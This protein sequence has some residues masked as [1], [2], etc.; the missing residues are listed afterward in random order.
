MLYFVDVLYL[1]IYL[2][3]Y[4]FIWTSEAPYNGTNDNKHNIS[5]RMMVNKVGY[6]FANTTK[7]FLTNILWIH[8]IEW[9]TRVSFLQC[10]Y[11]TWL[12]N[13][14]TLI[15]GSRLAHIYCLHFRSVGQFLGNRYG[16][17]TGQ[18][19]LDNLACTGSETHLFNCSHNG[20][21]RHNCGHMEDVSIRCYGSVYGNVQNYV[22]YAHSVW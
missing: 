14:V 5:E 2:S 18:I 11:S 8:S 22:E 3:I 6:H 4:L 12:L 10:T 19:W 1:F 15:C 20:W 21:G 17:G 9:M 7:T 13:D 16:P